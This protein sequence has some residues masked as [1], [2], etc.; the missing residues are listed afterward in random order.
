MRAHAAA[1]LGMLSA[2]L[3][4]AGHARSCPEILDDALRLLLVTTP[5]MNSSRARLK[6]F[7]RASRELPWTNVGT[8]EPA[9][10][11]RAGLAWG[12]GFDGTAQ[13]DEPRKVE[14]DGRTP[15]GMFR[16]GA[17]FGFGRSEV[18][19]HIAIRPGKTVCVDDASSP[20]YNTITTL[21]RVGPSTSREDMWRIPLY[22][23]GLLVD[24]PTD[25]EH[26]RGSC[27]FIHIWRGPESAT[28]GCIGLPEMRVAALQ[29]FS[30][31]GAVLAVLPQEALDRFE[32]CVPGAERDAGKKRQEPER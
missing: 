18:P 27:I 7:E 3:P 13:G 15:A 25:R 14:G 31:T 30:R 32:G 21:A 22:K 1:F 24:Y 5:A 12:H 9:V 20:L 28:A 8:A 16:I 23:R 6:V 2:L 26:R 10:V 11:G 17:S 19:G 29:E 4:S